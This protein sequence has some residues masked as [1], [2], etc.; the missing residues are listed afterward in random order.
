MDIQKFRRIGTNTN[1]MK[2]IFAK[3]QK[4]GKSNICMKIFGAK[5]HISENEYE[6]SI[7]HLN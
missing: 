4:N 2:E 5:K 1:V 7:K 6:Q 3:A